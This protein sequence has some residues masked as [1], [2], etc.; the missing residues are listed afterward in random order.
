[1]NKPNVDHTNNTERSN[2]HNGKKILLPCILIF[3]A[4]AFILAMYLNMYKT[5]AVLDDA[6]DLYNQGKYTESA[7]ILSELSEKRLLKESEQKLY[8]YQGL[9]AVQTEN[10]ITAVHY[11]KLAKNDTEGGIYLR[12]LCGVLSGLTAAGEKHTAL[13]KKDGTVVSCGDNNFNQCLTDAWS[14]ITAVAAGKNHTVGLKSNGTVCTA[15]D[16]SLGQCDV[17]DWMGITAIA[18]GGNHTVG[19][20]GSGRA[21]AAGNNDCGQCDVKSWS[22][23]ISAACG[24]RHSVGLRQDGTVVAAGDNSV[25]A[26]DVSDWSDIVSIAAGADFTVGVDYSGK[27]Y[28]TGDNSCNQHDAASINASYAGAGDY[29]VLAISDGK[30]DGFGDNQWYQ[31][32]V[33]VWKQIISASGGLRHCVGISSGGIAYTSGDNKS[34][35]CDVNGKE[36]FG[37]PPKAFENT[38]FGNKK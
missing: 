4:A 11:I 33:D 19:I 1:M 13:L 25:G 37:I 2:P 30:T 34:G 36:G 8:L 7:K 16:D 22:G 31:S 6:I 9:N 20:T 26:C 17:S 35:Q 29:C 24:E 12:Q 23:I 18:A 38:V 27:V 3:V 28:I 5:S 21:V 15:G 32:E 10:Y 14:N